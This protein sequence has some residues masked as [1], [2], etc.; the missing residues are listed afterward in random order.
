VF[1]LYIFRE[2]LEAT[3]ATCPKLDNSRNL[4]LVHSCCPTQGIA[5]NA[6]TDFRLFDLKK[7]KKRALSHFQYSRCCYSAAGRV[8]PKSSASSRRISISR[9]C[10]S[11][12]SARSALS[13]PA[14]FAQ[15]STSARW[16]AL[17]SALSEV[18]LASF[19]SFP[20]VIQRNIEPQRNSTQSF[21]PA[22]VPE[23][24]RSQD[25]SLRESN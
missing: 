7:I 5:I 4:T 13:A 2:I 8:R 15:Y 17:S 9:S 20:F 3:R 16:M 24:Y 23:P 11:R 6:P 22:K 14:P 21:T 1:P 19:I 18:I 12:Y 25:L 10:L